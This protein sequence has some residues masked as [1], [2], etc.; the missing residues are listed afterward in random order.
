[1]LCLFTLGVGLLFD[2]DTQSGSWK[3]RDILDHFSILVVEEGDKSFHRL[4][5]GDC[6]LEVNINLQAGAYLVN[7]CNLLCIL[8]G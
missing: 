5:Q 8:A 7:H 6:I 4:R 2:L 3:V 1:M